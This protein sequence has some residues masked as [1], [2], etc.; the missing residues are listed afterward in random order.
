MVHVIV[1]N[2]HEIIFFQLFVEL[3]GISDP[4]SGRRYEFVI[5][6]FFSEIV[7]QDLSVDKNLIFAVVCKAHD[8]IAEGVV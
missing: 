1:E 3:L 7:L 5:W 6:V 2:Y 4:L 8:E